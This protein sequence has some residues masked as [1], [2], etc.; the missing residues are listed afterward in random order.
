MDENKSKSDLIS[1]EVKQMLLG[2]RV[3]YGWTRRKFI[4]PEVQPV[5][6]L[7]WNIANAI[8]RMSEEEDCL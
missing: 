5:R 8:Q 7:Y 1:S 3:K 6:L 4:S 2:V